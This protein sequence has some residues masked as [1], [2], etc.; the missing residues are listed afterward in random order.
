MP[1]SLTSLLA[2]TTIALLALPAQAQEDASDKLTIELNSVEAQDGN[3]RVSFVVLNGFDTDLK[4]AVF[5]AVLFDKAGA[6][7]RMT[8][9]DFGSLP[10]TRTRVRQFVVPQLACDS[11][12]RV[13]INGAQTCETDTEASTAQDVCGKALNLRSRIDVEVIG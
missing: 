7:D 1:R 12:G 3:C 11:L 5:E 2:V 6:V 10:A 4:S 9:F 13:L 8:L